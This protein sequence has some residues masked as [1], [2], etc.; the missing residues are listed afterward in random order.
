MQIWSSICDDTLVEILQRMKSKY[1]QLQ[2]DSEQEDKREGIKEW[3]H[4]AAADCISTTLAASFGS[5]G[6]AT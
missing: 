4:P 6:L 1:G 2:F 5:N 3:L